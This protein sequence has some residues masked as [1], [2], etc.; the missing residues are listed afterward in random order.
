MVS[1]KTEPWLSGKSAAFSASIS[2]N[3]RV[4]ETNSFSF[5]GLARRFLIS[6]NDSP[7]FS[8]LSQSAI[9]ENGFSLRWPVICEGE[10]LLRA[11][12]NWRSAVV[13]LLLLSPGEK[14]LCPTFRITGLR[15]T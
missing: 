14:D 5:L 10:F 15:N 9:S 1:E 11:N 4:N 8:F 2:F 7:E 6:L 12:D 13:V 3:F